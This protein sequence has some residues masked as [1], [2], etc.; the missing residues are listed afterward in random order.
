[1]EFQLVY[2]TGSFSGWFGSD[3]G[4]ILLIIVSFIGAIGLPY[5]LIKS[6]LSADSENPEN[7][8]SSSGKLKHTRV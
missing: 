3:V 2:N 6:G 1:M 5:L 4:H 8:D 7:T